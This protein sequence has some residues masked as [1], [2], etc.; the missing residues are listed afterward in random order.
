MDLFQYVDNPDPLLATVARL[1]ARDGSAAEVSILANGQATLEQTSCDRWNGYGF[2]IKIV[3]RSDLFYQVWKHRQLYEKNILNT[4]QE[5]ARSAE[6]QFI[7]DVSIFV[8]VNGSNDWRE[9]AKD[10]IA[11][12]GITNQGRVR[13]DNVAGR[14]CDGLLFRS[15]PEIYLYQALKARGVSFAPLPVFVRGGVDYKRIEPDFFL[16]KDGLMMVVEVDGDTVHHE[17]PAEA[18]DRTTM[19]LHEGVKVERVLAS[20]CATPDLAKTCAQRLLSVLKK[21]KDNR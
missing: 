5:V 11:G 20:E 19:L 4:S 9:R 10:W 13:S 12:K 17:T 14:D 8:E 7:E 6:N 1:L 3:L 21:M 2:T 18:H 16:V 15:Q